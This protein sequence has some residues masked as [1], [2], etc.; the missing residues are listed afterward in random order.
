M[1]G[2]GMKSE[3]THIRNE[4]KPLIN[5][6]MFSSSESKRVVIPL[7]MYALYKFIN[8]S[9]PIFKIKLRVQYECIFGFCENVSARMYSISVMI[10]ALLGSS[11]CLVSIHPSPRCPSDPLPNYNITWGRNLIRKFFNENFRTDLVLIY[12]HLTS[13]MYRN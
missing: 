3:G 9:G 1:R 2:C 11:I 4:S 7:Y 5:H 13:H 6:T 8:K 12:F 10:N